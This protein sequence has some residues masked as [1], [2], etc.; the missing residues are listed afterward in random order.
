MFHRVFQIEFHPMFCTGKLRLFYNLHLH[1]IV[2]SV[3]SGT[4]YIV[5][6]PGFSAVGKKWNNLYLQFI[7]SVTMNWWQIYIGID[8]LW[9]WLVM[10]SSNLFSCHERFWNYELYSYQRF[11]SHCRF[12]PRP[13]GQVVDVSAPP[14]SCVVFFRP[15]LPP[16]QTYI[17]LHDTLFCQV[18]ARLNLLDFCLLSHRLPWTSEPPS[19]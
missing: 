7:P 18:F 5:S 10:A 12:L 16:P 17:S 14:P 19:M 8:E 2:G 4:S 15:L 6:P 11:P 3:F 13:I 1:P 9:S